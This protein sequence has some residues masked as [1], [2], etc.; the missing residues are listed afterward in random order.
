MDLIYIDPPFDTGV[1]DFSFTTRDPARVSASLWRVE[2]SII[3]LKAYRAHMGTR[4]R[5]ISSVVLQKR[6]RSFVTSSPENGSIYVHLDWHIGHYAK[7][8]LDEVFGQDNCLNEIIWKR[9]SARSDSHTFNHIHDVIYLYGFG[10]YRSTV[11][12]SRTIPDYIAAKYTHVDKNGRKFMLDNI[13]MIGGA[14]AGCCCCPKPSPP[15]APRSRTGC[16]PAR[17]SRLGP[18]LACIGLTIPAVAL[19]SSCGTCRSCSGS[20]RQISFY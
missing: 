8:V 4:A 5:L 17:T 10:D 11:V 6:R 13:T 16:E 9:T 12:M 14:I 2:P 1:Q 3:E 20:S 7:A 19:A 18:A 15:C